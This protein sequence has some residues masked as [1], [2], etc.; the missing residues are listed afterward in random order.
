MKGLRRWVNNHVGIALVIALAMFAVSGWAAYRYAQQMGLMIAADSGG[1][2]CG[3]AHSGCS[4]KGTTAPAGCGGCGEGGVTGKL[5][6]IG[7]M[8]LAGDAVRDHLQ[9]E[10]QGEA[11][12]TLQNMKTDAPGVVSVIAL[13][14]GKERHFRVDLSV[15]QGKVTEVK[16]RKILTTETR[17][18]RETTRGQD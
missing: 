1:G 5:F 7:Q 11:E 18:T 16:P 4:H 14:D 9:K 17:R 15:P 3:V 8:T 12:V 6:E 2:S 10:T 13:V